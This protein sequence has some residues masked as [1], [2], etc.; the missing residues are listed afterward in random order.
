MTCGSRDRTAEFRFFLKSYSSSSMLFLSFV[1]ATTASKRLIVADSQEHS[2]VTEGA[3][4]E[5]QWVSWAQHCGCHQGGQSA[6]GYCQV[7]H[8][9]S[10]RR[11]KKLLSQSS[12]AGVLAKT[13]HQPTAN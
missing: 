9:T 13:S 8:L 7:Q 1:S 4:L 3:K 10:F 11:C 2:S 6:H 12:L 5:Q